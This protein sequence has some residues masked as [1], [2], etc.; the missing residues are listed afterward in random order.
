MSARP[1]PPKLH[2]EQPVEQFPTYTEVQGL[3][4]SGVLVF[5]RSAG[6]EHGSSRA[7]VPKATEAD[8]GRSLAGGGRS[9]GLRSCREEGWRVLLRSSLQHQ[10]SEGAVGH[11]IYLWLSRWAV[12][13]Q[14]LGLTVS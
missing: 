10:R 9:L 2:K 13:F 14:K 7:R 11:S 4:G 8:R 3:C 1:P 5:R 6:R 12:Q